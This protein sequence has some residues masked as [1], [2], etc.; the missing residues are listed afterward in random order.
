V[1]DFSLGYVT[2]EEVECKSCGRIIRK[3]KF[4][5]D[6]PEGRICLDCHYSRRA[7]IKEWHEAPIFEILK[8]VGMVLIFL[9]FLGLVGVV[10]IFLILVFY[11]GA[12]IG[13]ALAVSIILIN[14]FLIMAEFGW[15]GIGVWLVIWF[16]ITIIVFGVFG[17]S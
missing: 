5:F 3:G 2:K 8:G 12:D 10:S 7:S 6:S 16:V 9:V 4:Q 11:L 13:E 1:K 15:I 14:P 17:K